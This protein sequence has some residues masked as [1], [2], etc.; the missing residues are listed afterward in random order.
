MAEICHHRC[1]YSLYRYRFADCAFCGYSFLRAAA[2]VLVSSCELCLLCWYKPV[3]FEIWLVT[4]CG[5]CLLTLYCCGQCLVCRYFPLDFAFCVIMFLCTVPF[6][7]SSSCRLCLFCWC[8]LTGNA[9][10]VCIFLRAVSF[11]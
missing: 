3:R 11:M 6:V 10:F 5:L 8:L 2:F 4:Y 7:L 9:F 1:L